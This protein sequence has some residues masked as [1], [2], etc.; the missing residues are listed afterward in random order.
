[1][2]T[3]VSC[4]TTT[5]QLASQPFFFRPWLGGG[6]SLT[7]PASSITLRCQRA[8]RPVCFGLAHE[9]PSSISPSLATSGRSA[10]AYTRA[11]PSVERPALLCPGETHRSKP[12]K[13]PVDVA[14]HDGHSPQA[15]E[16]IAP[17]V[18]RPTPGGSQCG[19]IFRH[20][21]IML[22]NNGKSCGVQHAGSPVVAH[23]TPFG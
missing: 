11:P 12:G 16:A 22:F 4:Q 10:A 8:N 5:P 3:A 23:T 21:A 20:Y 19:G 1:M 13:H 18:Y 14:V 7:F 9:P 2:Q 17:A 15:M 6:I